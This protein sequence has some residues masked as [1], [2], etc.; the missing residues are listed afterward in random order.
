MSL[1]PPN[2]NHSITKE[3]MLNVIK[4]LPEDEI[5]QCMQ[6]KDVSL[7]VDTI[8]I[9]INDTHYM[10]TFKNAKYLN[11]NF[12]SMF[13]RVKAFQQWKKNSSYFIQDSEQLI[14]F[15]FDYYKF[16]SILQMNR[17]PK[18]VFCS[19]SQKIQYLEL[20][21]LWSNKKN[22]QIPLPILS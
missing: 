18:Y 21:Q 16:N 5:K 1:P 15:Q 17:Y 11:Q 13:S 19:P 22:I 8:S 6:I 12:M 4:Y 7:F 9:D 2:E 20:S 10:S 14:N 3:M